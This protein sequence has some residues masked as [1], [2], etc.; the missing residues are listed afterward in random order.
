MNVSFLIYVQPLR[1]EATQ[2]CAWSIWGKMYSIS[3]YC[4]KIRCPVFLSVRLWTFTAAQDPESKVLISSLDFFI[5]Q[6]FC[7]L[8][9]YL[10]FMC[11]CVCLC[12]CVCAPGGLEFTEGT[13]NT[14]TRG[15]NAAK[16]CLTSFTVGEASCHSSRSQF[17]MVE[18]IVAM[19]SGLCMSITSL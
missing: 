16:S 4:N 17:L 12:V 15:L 7:L 14:K 2:V 11:V 8:C 18:V 19:A 6:S 10:V 9:V 3:K 5:L 13:S 1:S